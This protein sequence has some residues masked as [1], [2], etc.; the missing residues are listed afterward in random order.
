MGGFINQPSR[1]GTSTMREIS[2]VKMCEPLDWMHKVVK[3]KRKSSFPSEDHRVAFEELVRRVKR[4]M[5]GSGDAPNRMFAPWTSQTTDAKS[6]TVNGGRWSESGRFLLAGETDEA[7]HR[8]AFYSSR[9]IERGAELVVHYRRD[10]GS[11][12]GSV[13][14]DIDKNTHCTRNLEKTAA[15][16][17]AAR[18]RRQITREALHTTHKHSKAYGHALQPQHSL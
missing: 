15:L 5:G 18:N 12:V 9:C 13:D 3:T 8:I 2:N 7:I 10:E 14:A 4:D 16:M 6:E 1:A 11:V 17:E